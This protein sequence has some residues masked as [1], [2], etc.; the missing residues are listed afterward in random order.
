[1]MRKSTCG[2]ILTDGEQLVLGHVPGTG[3]WDIPKGG[4]APGESFLITAI[5][6]LYEET[7]L[8]ASPRELIELGPLCY[9]PDK[10]LILFL[11]QVERL[12]NP[13]TLKC[14]PIYSRRPGITVL[15]FDRF[16]LARW[17]EL[18]HLL[19]KRLARIVEAISKSPLVQHSRVLVPMVA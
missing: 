4:Q 11:W 7:G 2:V 12:P 9:R 10:D 6:E 3:R 13:K 18:P 1:M 8:V 15:E 14:R 16:R 17:D 5:R 19:P